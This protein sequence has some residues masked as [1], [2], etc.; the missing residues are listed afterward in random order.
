MFQFSQYSDGTLED[1]WNLRIF[2][3]LPSR[4]DRLFP[5]AKLNGY[6]TRKHLPSQ[7]ADL[8]SLD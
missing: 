7:Q 8:S 1:C 6:T 2:D 3:W 5:I 4:S